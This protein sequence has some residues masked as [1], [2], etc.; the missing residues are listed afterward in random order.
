MNFELIVKIEDNYFKG[1]KILEDK[2]FINVKKY[3]DYIFVLLDIVLLIYR[4]F[5]DKRVLIKIKL[6]ML[7]FIVY[8]IVL[9]N[10][11]LN[12]ILFI[13][14]IDDV[15]VIFFI[16]N[17]I[18]NDVLIFIIV[19]NWIGKNDIFVVIKNGIEYLSNFIKV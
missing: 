1:R 8:I 15:G 17:K 12:R 6:I 14:V 9:I 18:F 3:K 13:G 16:L 7:V 2:L 10:L 11:I 19:E 5:K 4:L